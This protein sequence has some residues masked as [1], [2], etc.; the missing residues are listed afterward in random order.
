MKEIKIKDLPRRQVIIGRMSPSKDGG[1]VYRDFDFRELDGSVL[2]GTFKAAKLANAQGNGA[3]M[4][5]AARAIL[6]PQLCGLD[7][8]SALKELT[9]PDRDVIFLI[10]R[11]EHVMRP[12]DE[13]GLGAADGVEPIDFMCQASVRNQDGKSTKCGSVVTYQKPWNDVSVLIPEEG[14]DELFWVRNYPAYRFSDPEN[15]IQSCT[16]RH[17]TGQIER[18]SLSPALMEEFP[19][20]PSRY[21]MEKCILEFNGK[22]VLTDEEAKSLGRSHLFNFEDIE[23]LKPRQLQGLQAAINKFRAGPNLVDKVFCP[24]HRDYVHRVAETV[25]HFFDQDAMALMAAT[26]DG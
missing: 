21:V 2:R 12:K 7:T 8:E 20:G 14:T 13:G 22:S 11:L 19:I 3:V 6:S 1:A 26:L 4:Q 16:M 15:G 25:T 23:R 5:E 9:T 10:S 24:R 17:V 18:D